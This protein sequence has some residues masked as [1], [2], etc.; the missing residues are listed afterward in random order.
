LINKLEKTG[1]PIKKK[2][3]RSSST[4]H[5]PNKTNNPNLI[6]NTTIEDPTLNEYLNDDSNLPDFEKIKQIQKYFENNV[7]DA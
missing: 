2:S 7:N 4:S 6:I 1:L 3:K 5:R